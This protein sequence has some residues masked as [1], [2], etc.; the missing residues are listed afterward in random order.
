MRTRSLTLLFVL[1]VCVVFGVVSASPAGTGVSGKI[2]KLADGLPVQGAPVTLAGPHQPPMVQTT[3]SDGSFSFGPVGSAPYSVGV[4]AAGYKSRAIA[5]V[6]GGSLDPIALDVATYTPLPIYGGSASYVA[7]DAHSGIFYA[8][9][10]APE[11]YRTLDYGGSW[12]PVTGAWDDPGTGL[13]NFIGGS[14]IATS[15]VSG[16]IAVQNGPFNSVLF[17]TDYGLT[18]RKIAGDAID[19]GWPSAINHELYWGHAAAGAPDVMVYAV[20]QADGSWKV[21]RADMSAAEPVFALEPSDPFGADSTITFA[22]SKTGSFVGRVSSSGSLSFAPL[23][24]DSPISFGAAEVTGLPTPIKVLRLGGSR[25]SNG[26]PD[27]VLVAGGSAPYEARMITKSNGESSFA[28]ASSSATTPLV[29]PCL[30]ARRFTGSVAPDTTGTSGAGNVGS[31]WL[32]KNGGGSDLSV[33]LAIPEAFDI[34]YDADYGQGNFVAMSPQSADG[35]RKFAKL[36]SG[37]IPVEED[38]P[39]AAGTDPGSGGNSDFGITAPS[40][41]GI[42]YGPV[43]SEFAVATFANGIFASKNGGSTL[44]RIAPGAGWWSSAVQWWHGASGDWLVGGHGTNCGDMLVAILDW[45]GSSTFPGPNVDGSSCADLGGPSSGGW[46]GPDP[47][48]YITGSIEP[49]PGTDTVFFGMGIIASGNHR[50]GNH[51]YRAQLVPGDPPALA[52]VFKFDSSPVT[53]DY[54]ARAMAYCPASSAY[55]GLRDVLLVATGFGYGGRA[56]AYGSLLRITGATGDSPS[57]AVVDSVPHDRSLS[58]LDDVRADCSSG[59]IYASGNSDSGNGLYKSVDGGTTFDQ[60][61]VPGVDQSEI[62]AIGL[63]PANSDDVTIAGGAIGTE[64]QSTDGGQTWTVVYDGNVERP[65]PVMDVEYP[66]VSGSS[67]SAGASA[68][69]PTRSAAAIMASSNTTSR[70]LVGSGSG[71]FRSDLSLKGG[72]VSTAKYPGKPWFATQMTRLV[73]DRNPALAATATGAVA[74]FHRTNGLYWNSQS[75]GSWSIPQS[76]SGTKAADNLPALA[77]A[78]NGALELAF[79]RTGSAHGIYFAARAQNGSWSKPQRV[80]S[81]AGDTL[82]AIAVTSGGKP[83]IYVA[84]LRTRGSARGVY[85]VSLQGKRWSRAAKLLGS[86]RADA[87][88]ALGRPSIYAHSNGLE[89]A[90][91]RT[92]RGIFLATLSGSRWSAPRRLSSLSGDSQPS[93]VI[94]S[95][96][97]THIV[98]R[99]S[100]GHARGLYELIGSKTWSLGK[101][102]NTAAGDREASLSMSGSTLVLAFARP[103][104][105]TAGV[106]FDRVTRGRWLAKPQRWSKGANDKNPSLRSAGGG[107]T[108]VFERG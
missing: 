59:V 12:Q 38:K 20:Q 104:G 98:F 8:S 31:C 40:V 97:K 95:G 57:V 83:R 73:S 5:G 10:S 7:A 72:I 26:P 23:T 85:Y 27:G 21:W 75:N 52:S 15:S 19:E 89:L 74:V 22:D 34:A 35:L 65:T 84:F 45:D 50:G 99:R 88:P 64:A 47:G 94:D 1:V 32:E 42:A 29:G 76:I 30:A 90:F 101:V 66:P 108:I 39:A 87:A 71:A 68:L 81:A 37:G 46:S 2:I 53:T 56:D 44:T 17:S 49:V 51:I 13:K 3:G 60:I 62:T 24:A 61:N 100:R 43:Q 105:K 25:G 18:W 55:A 107:L 96:G 86:S 63:N 6:T 69:A 28:G 78:K 58:A 36:D 16:E 79:A 9:V 92:G 4:S 91:A 82:P 102:T 11:V 41:Q 80:S 54:L 67:A 70:D 93:L 14:Q 77:R 48:G 103:S 33:S 106:Y